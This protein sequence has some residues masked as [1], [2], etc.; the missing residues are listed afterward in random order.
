M[1]PHSSGYKPLALPITPLQQA[2]PSFRSASAL[3]AFKTRLRAGTSTIARDP[4][5]N[6]QSRIRTYNEHPR[7][8]Q[9]YPLSYLAL[10]ERGIYILRLSPLP[11]L[12]FTRIWRLV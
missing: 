3:S 5:N 10:V 11:Q 12:R 6:Y 4:F 2:S 1:I 9:F 8:G 7:L